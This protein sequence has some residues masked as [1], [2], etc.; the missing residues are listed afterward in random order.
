MLCTDRFRFGE[1]SN[2]SNRFFREL[3]GQVIRDSEG[4]L[5][6]AAI[7]RSEGVGL[8]FGAGRS[9]SGLEAGS[10]EE[11]PGL[12]K[13]GVDSQNEALCPVHFCSD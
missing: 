10:A 3:S 2:I 7:F 5:G 6:I 12:L 9:G 11:H 1:P 13:I 8:V 4:F